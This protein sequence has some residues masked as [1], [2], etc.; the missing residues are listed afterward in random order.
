MSCYSTRVYRRS[1]TVESCAAWKTQFNDICFIERQPTTGL[2]S[3]ALLDCSNDPKA[4]WAKLQQLSQPPTTQQVQQTATGL[5]TYFVGKVQKI[6][7][8][9]TGADAVNTVKQLDVELSMF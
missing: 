5:M 7:A 9:T 2:H 4:L 3:T 6:H 8:S 1:L